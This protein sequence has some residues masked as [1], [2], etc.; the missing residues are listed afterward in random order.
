[1]PSAATLRLD[2]LHSQ[3][4]QISWGGGGVTVQ[5]ST[6]AKR[7][8]QTKSSISLA[9]DNPISQIFCRIDSNSPSIDDFIG[10]QTDRPN[11]AG[12]NGT[13]TLKTLFEVDQMLF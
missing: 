13:E 5:C 9:K 11:P 8:E 7:N 1:M 10:R 2:C 6:A 3:S 12:Q 4:V